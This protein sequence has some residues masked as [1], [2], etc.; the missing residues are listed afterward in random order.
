MNRSHSIII[1]IAFLSGL[2]GGFLAYKGLLS[3]SDHSVL[4]R[5]ELDHIE[6]RL[7]LLEQE[8]RR[9]GDELARIRSSSVL[10]FT[11]EELPYREDADAEHEVRS[12]RQK[13][14]NEGR[15]LMVTFGAN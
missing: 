13:A 9:L 7:L 5:T 3:L 14:R 6:E 11:G 2:V 1:A 8:N 12:A 10:D 4:S 15:F